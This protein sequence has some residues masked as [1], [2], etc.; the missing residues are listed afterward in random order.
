MF[1]VTLKEYKKLNKTKV[2]YIKKL[3]GSAKFLDFE[4]T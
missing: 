2:L 3:K 1:L 4:K